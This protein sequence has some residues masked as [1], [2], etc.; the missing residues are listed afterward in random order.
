MMWW[1]PPKQRQK[2]G[3]SQILSG[4]NW[5]QIFFDLFYVAGAYNLGN[6]LVKSSNSSVLLYACGAGLPVMYMWFD[7]MC[8]LVAKSMNY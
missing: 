3:D 8:K 6:V 1:S 7:K 4:G 2:W 5:S